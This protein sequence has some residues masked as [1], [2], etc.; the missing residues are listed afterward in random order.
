M[1]A[2]P[3]TARQAPEPDRDY[4]VLASRLPLRRLSATVRMARFI[5]QVRGQLSS[6]DGL[7]GYTLDARTLSREYW[8]LSAWTDADALGRFVAGLPHVEVMR[9]LKPDMG[10]THFTQWSAKGRDLP[11]GWADARAR[12]LG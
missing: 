1:P 8:T 5:I 2:L 9:R 3:W 4:L 10:P 12:V 11:P 6:A 7:V